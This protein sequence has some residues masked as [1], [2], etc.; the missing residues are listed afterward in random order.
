MSKQA[1]YIGFVGGVYSGT[2]QAVIPGVQMWSLFAYKAPD[3][4]VYPR[5]WP[6]VRP[7]WRLIVLNYMRMRHREYPTLEAMVYQSWREGSP[8]IEDDYAKVVREI[9]LTSGKDPVS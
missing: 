7:G 9:R 1:E 2:A 4:D 5:N 6:D 3:G 8:P